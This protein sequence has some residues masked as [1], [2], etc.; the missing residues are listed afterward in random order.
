[1]SYTFLIDANDTERLKTLSVWSEFP[2]ADLQ[3][4]PA[5]CAR[6][7]LEHMVHQCVSEDTWMKTMRTER[8]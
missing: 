2:D 1:M 5:G 4:R 6:T 3:F 7:P 8:P